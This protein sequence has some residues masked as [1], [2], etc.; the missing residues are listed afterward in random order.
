[1]AK[2]QGSR[3]GRVAVGALGVLAV[4]GLLASTLGVWS[5]RT[6]SDSDRFAA[7]AEDVVADP[8]V[9]SVLAAR[10]ST[11]TIEALALEER[12]E[13]L[14]PP[15]LGAVA[16][17][18]TASV[19]SAVEVQFERLLA[20]PSTQQLIGRIVRQ[21]HAAVLAI[22]RGDALPS[23][24]NVDDDTISVNMLPVVVAGLAA[25]QTR[26]GLLGEIELPD[27]SADGQPADQIAELET[28]FDRDL[29]PTFGQVVIYQGDA[30][31][32]GSYYVELAR[33]VVVRVNRWLAILVGLT[34]VLFVLSVVLSRRKW[35]AVLLLSVGSLLA[36]LISRMM[37]AAI[38]DR[39]PSAVAGSGARATVE[40]AVN[41]LVGG[42]RGFTSWLIV[43]SAITA[44]VAFWAGRRT[45]GDSDTSAPAIETSAEP[46]P[47]Q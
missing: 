11:E 36:V 24:V 28:A 4:V 34:V 47:A 14:V 46:E 42:L 38:L 13:S 37:I 17:I 1:M 5:K 41:D 32:Q 26:F 40:I 23:V 39:V 43:V 12:I 2:D 9:Q 29:P 3:V 25:L 20:L 6:L 16:G 27:L 15:A 44:G 19:Q 35:R 8:E 31:S 10:L 30:V 33:D 18:I 45:T 21:S 7:I 22:L